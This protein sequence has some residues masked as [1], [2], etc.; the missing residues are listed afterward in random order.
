MRGRNFKSKAGQAGF[1]LIE[2]FITVALIVAM[3]YVAFKYIPG[4]RNLFKGGNEQTALTTLT[5]NIKASALTGS[6]GTGD[7]LPSQWGKYPGYFTVSGTIAAPSVTNPDGGAITCTGSGGTAKIQTENESSSTCASI[8]ASISQNF[9]D[10]TISASSKTWAQGAIVDSNE[11][12]KACTGS[13][14]T[15]SWTIVPGSV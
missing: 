13:T 3:T 7:C 1:T 9:T 6:F 8:V 5:Q 2:L 14:N 10:A 15:V 12:A 4:V 11:A